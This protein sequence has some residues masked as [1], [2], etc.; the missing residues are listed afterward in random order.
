MAEEQGDTGERAGQIDPGE[1]V[2]PEG[3][4][5]WP[6]WRWIVVGVV[7]LALIAAGGLIGG[8]VALQLRPTS[9]SGCAVEQTAQAVLPTVV[10]LAVQG[11]SGASNG[12]GQVIDDDGN[13]LTNDHVISPAGSSGTIDVI[14]ND[15]RSVPATVVGRAPELDLAVVRIEPQNSMPVIKIGQ[16]SS[17]S[18]GE[19]V[20][21][22]GAPLGLSNTVTTGI[23]SAIGRDVPVP[24]DSGGH[25]VIAGAIQTDAAINPGNSGGALV[26]CSGR[27]VGVNTAIA[28]V[29][30]ASGESGGGNVGIGFAI[31]VDLAMQVAEQLIDTGN[32]APAYF[33]AET[34]PI[35]PDAASRLGLDGG[36]VVVDVSSPGPAEK[37]GLQR[38]DVI[39]EVDGK[40][41][42]TADS[43]WLITLQKKAGD[44][45]Q[46]K[47]T[48]DG[49]EQT[50]NVTLTDQPVR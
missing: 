37:A 14:F 5:S 25:A 15:G 41:T 3:T 13:V 34:T 9:G 27:L 47:Y 33:G 36:L 42:R 4:G 10:T 30:N 17:L 8:L 20:I 32:F 28:T 23:V 35:S 18:V 12:S 29:P 11:P 46:V 6:V 26:D 7:A 2:K 49:Q 44:T 22:L 31:P 1:Q 43:I 24:T 50:T 39:T 21:A 38:G 48:R 16:S 45:V 40:A 19:Q